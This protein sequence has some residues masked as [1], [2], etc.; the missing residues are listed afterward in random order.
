MAEIARRTRRR[1]QNRSNVTKPRDPSASGNVNATRPMPN[2]RDINTI[3]ASFSET[4]PDTWLKFAHIHLS[5][6]RDSGIA[7]RRYL[8]IFFAFI[9]GGLLLAGGIYA[10]IV[11]AGVH[12]WSAL[13]LGAGGAFTPIATTKRDAP[14]LPRSKIARATRPPTISDAPATAMLPATISAV[15][16]TGRRPDS[17]RTLLILRM[18]EHD[19]HQFSKRVARETRSSGLAR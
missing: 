10:V 11:V 7:L 1:G 9:A 6:A 19:P 5:S 8:I 15:L 2:N 16:P 14:R 17:S 13:L 3:Q 12:L 18:R 4:M